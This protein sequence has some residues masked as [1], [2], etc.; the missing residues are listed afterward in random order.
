M[1]QTVPDVSIEMLTTNIL[2]GFWVLLPCWLFFCVGGS[3]SDVAEN[4]SG[5]GG[6]LSGSPL[7]A[8]AP[9]L[10]I[11]H[12]QVWLILRDLSLSLRLRGS[13]EAGTSLDRGGGKSIR[14]FQI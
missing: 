2:G 10:C 14:R 4:D 9:H 5:V 3:R 11:H 12:V 7:A 13:I 1:K 6:I 8:D